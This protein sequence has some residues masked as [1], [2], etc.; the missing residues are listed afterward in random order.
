MRRPQFSLKTLLWVMTVAAI[1]MAYA[2]GAFRLW[3]RTS[4][5]QI[6]FDD[7]AWIVFAGYVVLLHV[8][9]SVDRKFIKR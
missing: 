2:T 7:Y 8:L 5:A 4:L 9:W 6:R 1:S 3:S